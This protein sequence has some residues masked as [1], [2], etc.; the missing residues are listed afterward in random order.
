MSAVQ[1]GSS[2]AVG[3]GVM[4]R[5]LLAMVCAGGQ[6]SRMQCT[7]HPSFANTCRQI[8][9]AAHASMLALAQPSVLR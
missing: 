7:R 2:L 6:L 4:E 5:I 8:F 1:P 3:Y 9:Q